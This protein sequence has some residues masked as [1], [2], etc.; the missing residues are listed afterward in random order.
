LTVLGQA[1]ECYR[2]KRLAGA[3]ACR[4]REKE[5]EGMRKKR[6]NVRSKEK[7]I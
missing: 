4:G 5:E 6:V 1:H 3:A 2:K 7:R